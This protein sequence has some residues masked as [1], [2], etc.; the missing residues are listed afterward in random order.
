MRSYS[1]AALITCLTVTV[2]RGEDSP[3]A[4]TTSTVSNAGPAAGNVPAGNT[5]T[6]DRSRQPRTLF[7]KATVPACDTEG[8]RTMRRDLNI[9]TT[10]A[11]LAAVTAAAG[12]QAV[13]RHQTPTPSGEPAAQSRSSCTGIERTAERGRLLYDSEPKPLWFLPILLSEVEVIGAISPGQAFTICRR[14]DRSTWNRRWAWLQVC[15]ASNGEE[16]DERCG[17]ITMPL[18]DANRWVSEP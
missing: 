13:E 5:K 11:I 12:V 15:V 1:T 9:L 4:P 2:R 18:Q 3:N 16:N 17:W 8:S 7:R 10:A 14:V 6:D